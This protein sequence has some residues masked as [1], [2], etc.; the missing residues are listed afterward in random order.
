MTLIE[1]H[2][3]GSSRVALQEEH[4]GT[5]APPVPEDAAV[6]VQA[7]V[8]DELT[9]LV[10][11]VRHLDTN[12]LERAAGLAFRLRE[13]FERRFGPEHAN[14]LEAHA[15]EA[16][17]ACRGGNPVQA[18]AMCIELAWI[19]HWQGDL[20]AREEVARTTAAWLRIDEVHAAS[21]T[22][23]LCLASCS[24]VWSGHAN[25]GGRAVADA[26]LLRLVS[27]RMRTLTV[28]PDVRAAGAA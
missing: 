18:A 6:L 26:A 7:A 2:P 22:G 28:E 5:P 11:F 16:Y 15:L 10:G 1:V 19:R 8:R 12:A 21:T 23:A 17:V 4:D 24:P 13:H 25:H 3:D 14:R 27:L 20:R 9:A